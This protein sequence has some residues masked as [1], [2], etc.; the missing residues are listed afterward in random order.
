MSQLPSRGRR[1][2]PAA[3][4]RT[5]KIVRC[6]LAVL[7]GLS[8]LPVS[9][10]LAFTTVSPGDIVIDGDLS[11][12]VGVRADPDNSIRDTQIPE[13]P[14]YPGQPDRDIYILAAT[15]DDDYLYLSWRRTAGG[16][17]L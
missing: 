17:N 12:W 16:K 10:S 13:D 11:D 9:S 8:V 2:K 6:A 1:G 7:V 5:S 15:Y 14:D 3:V 4:R